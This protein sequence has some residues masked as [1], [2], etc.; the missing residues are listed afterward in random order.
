[1]LPVMMIPD[2]KRSHNQSSPL[3][4]FCS[5]FFF[6]FFFRRRRVSLFLSLA[7]SSARAVVGVVRCSVFARCQHFSESVFLPFPVGS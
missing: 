4:Y 5:F 3:L 2:A 7:L 1:M 6:R